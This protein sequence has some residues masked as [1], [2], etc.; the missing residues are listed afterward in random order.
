MVE[1]DK[2]GQKVDEGETE[3][4]KYIEGKRKG[5]IREPEEEEI[6]RQNLERKDV[7]VPDHDGGRRK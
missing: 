2:R 4:K 7:S 6:D 3:G 1:S 5:D